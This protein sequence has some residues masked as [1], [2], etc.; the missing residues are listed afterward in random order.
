MD[1]IPKLVQ[2]LQET[3]DDVVKDFEEIRKYSKSPQVSI[4]Q[5]TMTY[6]V[7]C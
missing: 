1:S 2:R 7:L 4:V 6:V 3:P 5:D